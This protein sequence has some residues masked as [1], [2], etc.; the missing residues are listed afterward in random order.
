MTFWG[1]KLWS[2]RTYIESSPS[3]ITLTQMS[4]FSLLY[5]LFSSS[6]VHALSPPTA[7]PD[8]LPLPGCLP[9]T[10]CA[11]PMPS[12]TRAAA[13]SLARWCSRLPCFRL[14]I[15][16]ELHGGRSSKFVAICPRTWSH[17]NM[18]AGN[19][20]LTP[21]SGLLVMESSSGVTGAAV[22]WALTR[23]ANNLESLPKTGSMA[24]WG[25]NIW[26]IRKYFAVLIFYPSFSSR[27]ANSLVW[28]LFQY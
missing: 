10:C 3:K 18:L 26:H 23:T 24:Y 8:S 4:V 15:S 21:E 20:G 17:S 25:F 5:F 22:A 6:L 13:C 27:T 19:W 7:V 12:R 16:S 2:G 9:P 1:K 14:Q 11:Y 28:S